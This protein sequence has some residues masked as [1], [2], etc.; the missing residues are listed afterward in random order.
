MLTGLVGRAVCAAV[1]LCQ[2]ANA[3]PTPTP[4]A[5]RAEGTGIQVPIRSNSEAL[6]P[7]NGNLEGDAFV[8][9]MDRERNAL[10]AKY[11]ST[12]KHKNAKKHARQ[13]VGI[14]NYGQNSFYFMPIGI[15]T[16][17]TTVNVLMDTGSSDFWIADASC[18]ELTGCSESMTLYDPSKSSTFNSSDRTFL[19][20]YGDGTNTVSG[21]LG[22]DDVTMAEYQVD[23]LTFGRVSQLT[24]STI[25][26]PASGL[27]GMGFESLSSSESTPFWEVVAL[28]GK[29]KDPVFSFQLA[30]ADSSDSASKVV[31][32][33]VF[34]LGVLDDRQ[35]TGDIAWVDLTEGYGS[36]GIGYWAITMDKLVANGE[37][38]ELDQQNIVAVDTGT[39]LI[40]GPQSIL[41]QIYS[42]IPGVRSAPSYLLGGSGYYMYPCTQP[43]TLKMTF[44]GKEFTL[45]NENLNLGRLSS[46]SNMCISS[47][48]DAPQSQNSAMPAWILGD[49]FLRTVF[50]VYSWN[51]ERVGFASLPS[52]GASTLPMTS[53]TS[54]ETFSDAS[55]SLAGGGSVTSSVL[56]T[57]SSSVHSRQTGLLGGNGLPTPSLV[58]VPTGFQSLASLRSYGLGGNQDNGV[59]VPYSVYLVLYSA[60]IATVTAAFVL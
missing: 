49:T 27:M 26:P 24:G 3:E 56:L 15:G 59:Q 22:A 38:I 40:G 32:G 18:S 5:H 51:P 60:V 9:W 28:Q 57:S 11:N 7:R 1:L 17:S 54:G 39:T 36:Q 37:T 21:N 10:N 8:Q 29:V 35:Y 41:R 23:G 47:L 58:S 13:L 4:S 12:R 19:T 46:R 48:F 44:G 43:F 42:Q 45:D 6:H 25:Q 34:S 50:S 52:G 14:G 16:P 55:T 20:P 31:P 33:G 30:S 2:F 53:I